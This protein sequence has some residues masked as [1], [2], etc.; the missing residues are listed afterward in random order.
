MSVRRKDVKPKCELG[1]Q[2]STQPSIGENRLQ[3][4]YK[5]GVERKSVTNN[6]LISVKPNGIHMGDVDIGDWSGRSY[7]S[8][9]NTS[10]SDDIKYINADERRP[11]GRPQED[12][13]KHWT[14]G[15]A[16]GHSRD[17]VEYRHNFPAFIAKKYTGSGDIDEYVTLKP[18]MV[19]VTMADNDPCFKI[20]K[21]DVDVLSPCSND[22]ECVSHMFRIKDIAEHFPDT[23]KHMNTAYSKYQE[24]HAKSR[25]GYDHVVAN[26]TKRDAEFS[27]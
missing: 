4:L 10:A 21:Q 27:W 22:D 25:P 1:F 16:H 6:T 9:Q 26:N 24:E 12:R 23:I 3:Q 8:Y 11:D 14:R 17:Y 15:L 7:K 2:P 5:M 18:T 20:E 13:V 19:I